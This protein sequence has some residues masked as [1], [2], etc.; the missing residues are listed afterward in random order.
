MHR[1]NVRAGRGPGDPPSRQPAGE[2]A[3]RRA[4]LHAR[5]VDRPG[6]RGAGGLQRRPER[7]RGGRH[8]GAGRGSATSPR[9]ISR[10]SPT[11]RSRSSAS[12]SA[13]STRRSRASPARR[14]GCSSSSSAWPRSHATAGAAATGR[15]AD[16][17]PALEMLS[18]GGVAWAPLPRPLRRPARRQPG[19]DARG[20]SG[21]RGVLRRR[22]PAGTARG[23]GCCST[24]ASSTSSS[25]STGSTAR[26]PT[27][28]G[29][30]T[31]SRA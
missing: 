18:H 22:R 12:P 20:L 2:P 6:A 25:P 9:A 21:E 23:C 16:I 13:P 30:A 27:A 7:Y 26:S 3:L 8:A 31:R 24:T 29:S 10:P 5:R 28:A 17:Y 19:G 1:A 4:R 14:A 15:I 11:G